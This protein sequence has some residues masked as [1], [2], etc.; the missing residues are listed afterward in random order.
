MKERE[1]KKEKERKREKERDR[2][3]ERKREIEKKKRES[4]FNL[5]ERLNFSNFKASP[6]AL[7]PYRYRY[8]Y[9]KLY[10]YNIY[11]I[12]IV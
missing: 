12:C 5:K 7:I 11:K 6:Y 1:S 10:T 3:R 4:L 2:E 8:I 9:S